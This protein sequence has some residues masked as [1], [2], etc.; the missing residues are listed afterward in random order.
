MTPLT[1]KPS[2]T[3]VEYLDHAPA[4]WFVLDVLRK[5]SRKRNWVALMIDMHPEDFKKYRHGVRK[6]QSGWVLIPGKHK[7]L[8]DAWDALENLIATRH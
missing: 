3:T 5:A 7:N 2:S 1:P 6:A 4:G 8:D